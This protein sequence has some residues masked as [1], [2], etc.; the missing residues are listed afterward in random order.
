MG[1]TRRCA[2]VF[3]LVL[4]VAAACGSDDDDGEKSSPT[5][6]KSSG[7]NVHLEG[8]PGVTDTE[9]NFAVIG[10]KANN[11]LG[12][13]ILDCYLS[14]VRAHFAFRNDEGGIYGRDLVVSKVLDDELTKNQVRAKEIISANDVFAGFQATLYASG[15]ADLDEAGMPTFSW[16]IHFNEANGRESIFNTNAMNCGTCTGRLVPYAAASVKAKRAASLGYG[17]SQNSKDCANAVANSY[18][19]YKAD[20]GVDVVYVNDDVA[21]GM[22]N[23]IGPEVTAMKNAKVDFISTCFDLNG[24]KTL[25]Q[26]LQRQGMD[27]VVLYHPNTYDQNFVKAAGDLFEGDIV[28]IQFRAFEAD[29][30][31]SA[32]DDFLEWMKKT[33]AK[34]TELAM[35]G[36]INATLA[37]E[38]LEA[39]GPNFDRAKVIAAINKMTAFSADGLINPIDWTRQHVPPT[40][41]DPYTHGF[42]KE[43]AVQVKVVNGAFKTVAPKDKPWICFDNKTRDWSEPEF[44]DFK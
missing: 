22:P 38:G 29:A 8:V 26:E 23:G 3:A 34:V 10:T 30:S 43:C 20:T 32:L 18:R 19:E 6:S 25:A 11:P 16:G 21:F 42:L 14:G 44:T 7:E 37:Y 17:V 12:T 24:M 33:N 2:A 27:D 4:L 40:Q 39:A 31:G 28:S 5:T 13:C 15:W 36:W 9:I 41:D 1:L 35:Q